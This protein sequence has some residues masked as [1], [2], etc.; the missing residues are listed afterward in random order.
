MSKKFLVQIYFKPNLVLS[1]FH[2][3]VEE[4]VEGG[5]GSTSKNESC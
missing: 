5:G 2:S 3:G 1:H 4:E